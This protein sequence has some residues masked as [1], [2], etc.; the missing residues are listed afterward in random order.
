[1]KRGMTVLG[2]RKFSVITGFSIQYSGS[3]TTA[4]MISAGVALCSA[5]AYF[6]LL[7]APIGSAKDAAGERVP[8]TK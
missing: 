7:Q 4:F 2:S 8:A 6:L 3:F 5:V 1:V